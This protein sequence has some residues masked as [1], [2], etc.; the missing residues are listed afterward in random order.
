MMS[1]PIKLVLIGL[2][3]AA[4]FALAVIGWGGPAAFFS[5]PARIALAVVVL[6]LAIGSSKAELE[7]A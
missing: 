1:W 3:T 5:H 2:S 7:A 4:Y 6:V